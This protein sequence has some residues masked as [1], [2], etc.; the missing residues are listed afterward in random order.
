MRKAA[1]A[2]KCLPPPP[3]T[4]NDSNREKSIRAFLQGQ[5]DAEEVALYTLGYFALEETKYEQEVVHESTLHFKDAGFL[6]TTWDPQHFA[7][8]GSKCIQYAGKDDREIK[9]TFALDDPEFFSRK[10]SGEEK[11]HSF[12]MGN[13]AGS[14]VL[15]CHTKAQLRQWLAI[16]HQV[17]TCVIGLSSTVPAPS[18]GTQWILASMILTGDNVYVCREDYNTGQ[19]R[20]LEKQSIDVVAAL[21]AGN[22]DTALTSCILEFDSEE[23]EHDQP[24][25]LLFKTYH[26]LSDFAVTLNDKW[27]VSCCFDSLRVL[28][29]CAFVLFVCRGAVNAGLTRAGLRRVCL[30]LVLT[31]VLIVC[32]ADAR[33]TVPC[34]PVPGTIPSRSIGYWHQAGLN[35][36]APQRSPLRLSCLCSFALLEVTSNRGAL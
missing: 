27:K 13:A 31:V 9:A 21:R 2:A 28:V 24:W 26:G 5:D 11:Q 19:L 6:S 17:S 36:H 18:P 14:V 8:R 35:S 7:V 33:W 29:A 1:R 25:E 34:V 3:V 16:L 10:V 20:L 23:T 22:K 12:E 15:A 32:W 4:S 30:L